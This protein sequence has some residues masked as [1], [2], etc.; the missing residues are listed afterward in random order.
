MLVIQ[1]NFR[2]LLLDSLLLGIE[3]DRSSAEG[4]LKLARLFL[5]SDII[6]LR[7][8][9]VFTIEV[10]MTLRVKD[11]PVSSDEAVAYT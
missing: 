10:L 4:R 6:V 11:A 1:L 3:D 8:L 2:F 7:L 9:P 5:R